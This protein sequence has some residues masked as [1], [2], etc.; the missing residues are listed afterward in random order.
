MFPKKPNCSNIVPIFDLLSLH[1]LNIFCQYWGMTVKISKLKYWAICLAN[2]F[3]IGQVKICKI[4][5]K[6]IQYSLGSVRQLHWTP[7]IK[8]IHDREI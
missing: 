1:W 5:P 7:D 8:V 2:E 6:C 3:K 4:G